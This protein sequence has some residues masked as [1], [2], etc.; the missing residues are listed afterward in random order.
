M[1][2]SILGVMEVMLEGLFS[3]KCDTCSY[4]NS[5]PAVKEPKPKSPKMP[6]LSSDNNHD[7]PVFRWLEEIS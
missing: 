5:C 1:S 2:K 7:C 6:V 3:G 4:F